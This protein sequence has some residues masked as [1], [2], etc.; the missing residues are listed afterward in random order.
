[1]AL[2]FLPVLIFC[3][4]ILS[5]GIWDLERSALC[6]HHTHDS[7]HVR[8]AAQQLGV[9]QIKVHLEWPLKKNLCDIQISRVK[10]LFILFI[11]LKTDLHIFHVDIFVDECCARRGSVCGV[12]AGQGDLIDVVV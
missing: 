10:G 7:K 8:N 1:M 12:C 11:L 5:S 9:F 6:P 2:A 3:F 4:G